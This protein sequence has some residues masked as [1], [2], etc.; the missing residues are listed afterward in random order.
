MRSS[1]ALAVATPMP[2]TAVISSTLACFSRAS[3]PKWVTSALRRC[4]PSPRTE[5]SAEAVIRLD[6]LLR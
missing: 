2:G 3:D 4:S 5:S 1:T 6:R